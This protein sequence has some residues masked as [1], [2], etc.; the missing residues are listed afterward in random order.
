[1]NARQT[2]LGAFRPFAIA[3]VL[4]G[5]PPRSDKTPSDAVDT[6][7]ETNA[8]VCD[9]GDAAWVAR[10][11]PLMWGRRAH[12]AHEIGI[13]TRLVLEHDRATAIRAMA[14]APDYLPWWS[15]WL[16]DKLQVDRAG[17]LVD[18]GC[19]DQP[20]LPSPS[21]DLADF[22]GQTSPTSSFDNP[23]NMA[24]VI[25]SSVLAD[26]LSVAWRSHL[27]GR[28]NRP[29]IAS[30]VDEYGLEYNRR[31]DFGS[32]FL[33]TYIN[34]DLTCM[35]CHNSEASVTGNDDPDLDRTWEIPGRFE[36][37]LFGA[38]TG[39]DPDTAYQV[40]RYHALVDEAASFIQPWGMSDVCGQI[41]TPDSLGPDFLGESGYF[42][43]D[44]GESGSV[45][46]VE[47][48][49]ESGVADLQANG[50]VVDDQ[51]DVTPDQSLAYLLAANIGDLVWKEATGGQLTIANHFPR[52]QSQRDRLTTV[53]EAL[54]NSGFSLVE[55]LVAV[56]ADEAFNM[57]A[58]EDCNLDPYGFDPLLDPW[59]IEDED[60]TRAGNGPGDR[61]HRRSARQLI[62]SVHD[63]L[64]WPQPLDFPFTYN[65][66]APSN[67]VPEGR[68]LDVALGA[69]QSQYQPESNG[70]DFQGLLAF[71]D[72]Y[73]SCTFPSELFPI[74][75]PTCGA[76]NSPRCFDCVCEACV[77]AINTACCIERWSASCAQ[78]CVDDCGGCGEP[79]DI[80]A[81]DA[82]FVDRLMN[83][84]LEA[85]GTVG[86]AVGAIRDRLL[87]DGDIPEAEAAL[88]VPLI[89]SD[90]D[91]PL[92]T[93]HED[94]L[95]RACGAMLLSP[96][97]Y[98]DLSP[99][100]GTAPADPLDSEADCSRLVAAALGIGIDA[101]CDQ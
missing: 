49:I 30:N 16:K 50:L 17:E 95:R 27:F 83:Q 101:T 19:Y 32:R 55:L 81:M 35:P 8:G 93:D 51:L 18:P 46:T 61:V 100:V 56:T 44:L 59:T 79:Q 92:T 42:G 52:N 10:A 24:D 41:A 38:S 1:M 62:R 34:R 48:L 39:A 76:T 65:P 75:N 74:H 86:D 77:C 23:F 13:W 54:A 85:D 31:I 25:A 69:Y 28:L 53:A 94:G 29:L 15:V 2:I 96:A 64:G 70:V 7:I 14:K 12:G 84:T 33:N 45:W 87:N 47:S 58:V 3:V 66:T 37:A 78:I 97:F 36:L 91:D 22:I 68:W 67:L 26:D 89:E 11:M 21:G 90:L 82:D 5:C 4:A 73:A 43:G 80:A 57:S 6:D 98:L 40:F 60:P 71:E 88:L 72:T 63:A 99:L 20:L 9:A